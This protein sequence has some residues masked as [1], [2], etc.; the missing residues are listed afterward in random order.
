[1]NQI[2]P[3]RKLAGRP[4]FQE[5]EGAAYDNFRK[6]CQHVFLSREAPLPLWEQLYQHLENLIL[7]GKLAINSRIPSEPVLCDLFGVSKAVVR[8][9]I[10][11]LA[12]KGLV[13]KIPRKGMF[14][15]ERPRESGFVTSNISLFDDMIAR[16]AS[17]DTRTFEFVK[18]TADLAEQRG[19]LLDDCDEVIRITR[20]FW[21]D[22]MPITHSVI[23]FPAAKLPGFK[24]EDILN[25]SILKAIQERFGLKVIRADRWL[26]AKLP[27]DLVCERMGL[28]KSR[29]L[30]HI[31]SIGYDQNG[32]RLEYYQAY[33]NTEAARIRLSVSD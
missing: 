8:H 12:A 14:V 2:H 31:E 5:A 21:V 22:N 30:I 28:N 33:Y 1:M 32:E 11:A 6:E 17:I 15:C 25:S 9:A 29:P 20:V 27:S 26:D 19:L 10:S 7:S 18:D 13:V 4:S 23:S 24:R 3:K 16:G